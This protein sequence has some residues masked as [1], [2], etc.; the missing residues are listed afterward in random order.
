M[1]NLTYVTG[2]YGKYVAVKDAFSKS[3]IDIHFFSCDLDEADIN[4]I[5][6]ISKEKA[7]EAFE[8]VKSPV[9]VADCGFYIENYPGNP[10]YPGAFVK[11]SGVSSDIDKLLEIMK[12]VD[13]RECYFLDC[14]TFYD[15]TS[16]EQFFGKSHGS[17]SKCKRGNAIK[18]SKSNLWYVFVPESRHRLP[19]AHY[20]YEDG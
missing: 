4:D 14:L 3:G 9:I 13:N 2:N 20:H 16:F 11:R 1:E 15:G 8:I 17:L 18:K 5:E 10:G 7:Q 12:D 6:F 19:P